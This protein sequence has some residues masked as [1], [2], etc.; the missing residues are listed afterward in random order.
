MPKIQHL[1][2]FLLSEMQ[3]RRMSARAFADFVGVTHSTINKFLGFGERE[4]GY[5]SVDFLV[6]LA[7]ATKTDIRYLIT[8][9]V[10]ESVLPDAEISTDAVRLSKKIEQLPEEYRK[11]IDAILAIA[12]GQ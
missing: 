2:D 3:E 11:M 4:V 10:P 8:L 6:K 9:V 5:P 7:A 1:G 12:T